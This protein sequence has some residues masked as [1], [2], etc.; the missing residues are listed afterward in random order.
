MAYDG[1]YIMKAA[2]EATKSFDGAVL[3]DWMEKNAQNVKG[4]INGPLAASPNSHF[5]VGA[6]AIVFVDRPDQKREDGA[7]LRSC[8]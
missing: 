7:A 8:I 3:A 5:L 1:V 4:R 6:D 2:V